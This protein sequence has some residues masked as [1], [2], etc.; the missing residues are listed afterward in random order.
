M[1]CTCAHPIN[2]KVFLTLSTDSKFKKYDS[3]KTKNLFHIMWEIFQEEIYLSLLVDC[4][5]IISLAEKTWTESID[6]KS[7]K[8][9]K[10]PK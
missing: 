9:Y 5:L 2:L 6:K 1:E 3:L 7:S 10:W 4:S 8:L